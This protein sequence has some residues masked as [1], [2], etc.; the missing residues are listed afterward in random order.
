MA[1]P[2]KAGSS[3]LNWKIFASKEGKRR[4]SECEIVLIFW[5]KH[6]NEV[7]AKR[8]E[9]LPI[10]QKCQSLF[11]WLCRKYCTGWNKRC[12][13]LATH[14]FLFS[15]K[16]RIYKQNTYT[17]KYTKW[18]WKL[19]ISILTHH[20]KRFFSVPSRGNDKSQRLMSLWSCQFTRR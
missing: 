18:G 9:K 6:E 16:N 7:E 13:R 14:V 20:Y 1:P 19:S 4:L 2:K 3:H 8:S 15:A 11:T 10:K 17:H 12:D 5:A